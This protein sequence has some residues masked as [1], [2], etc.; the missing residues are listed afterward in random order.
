MNVIL[1]RM[2]SLLIAIPALVT[3][4]D[5]EARTYAPYTAFA[6]IALL[7]SKAD[8]IMPRLA[9]PILI[10]ELV[11]FSWFSYTYGGILYLLPFATLI[12]AF[13]RGAT[14]RECAAWTAIGCAALTVGLYGR[15]LEL[16]VSLLVLWGTAAGM[17]FV[18]NDF[19]KKRFKFEEL[20]EALTI[21][22]EQLDAAK[23]RMKDYAAQ[24][25]QYAQTEERNRIAKDIHDDL[26][27]RLIRV[28]MMSEA[29]LHLFDVDTDRARGILEQIR[30]QLQDSMER[31]RRTVRKLASDSDSEPRRY[32]LDRLMAESVDGQGY[33]VRFEVHGNPRPIYPSMELILFKNAQ[34][35]ITNAVRHG[36]ATVITVDLRFESDSVSLTVAN[37][38]MLPSEPVEAGLGIRGMR[39]RIALIGGRLE[40]A[41]AEQF[42]IT[43]IL[44]LLTK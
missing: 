42:A 14:V 28:K 13:R 38:G 8:I 2:R 26:G 11:F 12:A 31:M 16:I 35:A 21:S 4:I 40:V 41:T 37:D 44:P 24:I 5:I 36:E 30:D 20:Y 9:G 7:I 32:A 17:L 3:I 22:N 25:E 43:T 19:E 33:E 6:L 1:L 39:E 27:H 10:A 23:D 29:A 18:T 15:E 34:E